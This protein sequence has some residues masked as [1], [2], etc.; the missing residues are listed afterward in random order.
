MLNRQKHISTL[1]AAMAAAL[2]LVAC[3]NIGEEGYEEHAVGFQT[4]VGLAS[5]ADQGT[6]YPTDQ[7]FAATAYA[8]PLGSTWD[9]DKAQALDYFTQVEVGYDEAQGAWVASPAQW[10]PSTYA[11]TFFAHSPWGD[12]NGN[13]L[14]QLSIDTQTN[15]TVVSGWDTSDE[16]LSG[17]DLM[18]ADVGSSQ[19]DRTWENTT[20]GVP[21]VFRHLLARVRV[22]AGMVTE[23]T[24]NGRQYHIYVRRVELRQV[25]TKGNYTSAQRWE[26]LSAPKTILLYDYTSE[27]GEGLD[28]KVDVT[29]VGG[30][31]MLL[32]QVHLTGG[33]GSEA[34]LY[35]EWKDTQT[36]AVSS[37]VINLRSH[38]ANSYWAPNTHYTYYLIWDK[39]DPDYI[40]FNAPTIAEDWA[41]GGTYEMI[42]E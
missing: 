8:L 4:V 32:P 36:G 11:L 28:L 34:E 23:Y 12:N 3:V 25:K 5:R 22:V 16:A 41:N 35:V 24:V 38:I 14:T 15:A 17:I 40:E 13:R 9:T 39:G 33:V 20:G 1:L 26:E 30:D 7:T 42:I 37:K 27:G 31:H 18:V 29:E 10:W 19:K 21:T 6:T 2:A